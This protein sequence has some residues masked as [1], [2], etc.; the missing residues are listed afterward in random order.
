[1]ASEH[2]KRLDRENKAKTKLRLRNGWFVDDDGLLKLGEEHSH[3]DHPL[4]STLAKTTKDDKRK[5]S[6]QRLLNGI[7][8]ALSLYAQ[9][10]TDAEKAAHSSDPLFRDIS[11]Q[12]RQ[13]L[14]TQYLTLYQRILSVQDYLAVVPSG[15]FYI[16]SVERARKHFHDRLFTNNDL[17]AQINENLFLGPTGEG[18]IA[19]VRLEWQQMQARQLQQQQQ[20]LQQQLLQQQQQ[21]H[22]RNTRFPR[23]HLQHTTNPRQSNNPNQPVCRQFSNGYCRYANCRYQHVSDTPGNHNDKPKKDKKDGK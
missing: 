10:W 17:S 19:A 11:H 15:L 2:L 7:A 14:Q 21:Q 23:P 5:L 6:V 18:T 9:P 1:M 8:V 3:N 16:V 13:V 4:A 20:T 12:Q 22:R